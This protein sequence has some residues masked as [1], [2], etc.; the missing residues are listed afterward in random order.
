MPEASTLVATQLS[1]AAV[2]GPGERLLRLRH[3]RKLMREEILAVVVLLLVL[4][5][6]VAV[7]ATQWLSSGSSTAAV[8]N[9]FDHLISGG[10]T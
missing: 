7:L 3:R 1:L 6:T 2:S 10:T 8:S 4:A 5:A 9:V